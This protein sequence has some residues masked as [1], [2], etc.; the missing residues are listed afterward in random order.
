M[1]D[2][3][4][5]NATLF[6]IICNHGN[7]PISGNLP[8]TRYVFQTSWALW[9]TLD[10]IQKLKEPAAPNG[11]YKFVIIKL[12][13]VWSLLLIQIFEK[14]FNQKGCPTIVYIN[15]TVHIWLF[16]LR[17]SFRWLNYFPVKLS[18]IRKNKY[19]P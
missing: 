9:G 17:F 19:I 2:I 6:Y 14:S 16:N 4:M 15:K 13:K 8:G 1:Q 7:N 3:W 18:C 10:K 5:V 12:H 11:H